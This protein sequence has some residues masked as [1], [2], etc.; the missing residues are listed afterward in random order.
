MLNDIRQGITNSFS[1]NAADR[2]DSEGILSGFSGRKLI[3]LLQQMAALVDPHE[4]C[5]LEVG[6]FQGL[7]LLSV[8]SSRPELPC[9][10][11]DNFAYFDPE[12]KNRSI[13]RERQRRLGANNVHL[14]DEDYEDAFDHLND[15]LQGRKIGVYFIDGPHD[16]RS[17]LMCLQLALPF[18]ADH[19]V[20]IVDDSN[21]EHVRMA[22]RDFMR[23]HPTFKLLFESY[24]KAHPQNLRGPAH[25]A[26]RAGWWNGVNLLVRDPDNRL[27]T[28]YPPTLRNRTLYEN[29]SYVHSSRYAALLP[30]YLKVLRYV[31]PVWNALLGLKVPLP[32]RT[33]YKSLNT[34]SEDLPQE[35][36]Y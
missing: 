23:T 3:T 33:R 25:S 24:T 8:A 18:L 30:E 26:A 34:F 11:I 29:D 15:H 27:S 6:V 10:G 5:Y 31:A 21:Y 2:L 28:H 1:P 19:A 35:K 16:Y 9:F 13:I 12:N 20:I 17:Q 4:T 22:N 32:F 7:T 14:I 36:L